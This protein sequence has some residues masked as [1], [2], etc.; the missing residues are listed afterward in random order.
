MAGSTATLAAIANDNYYFV[1]WGD[2]NTDNPR[3][4][5]VDQ[6]IT[7]AA[8]FNGTGVDENDGTAIH[9]Y[10]NPANDKIRLEG[11]EGDTEISIYNAFGICVKALTINGENEVSVN[12][13]AAGLYL[14]RID[15]HQTVKFV[16][17]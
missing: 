4:I 9:L 3:T 12:D 11:L 16:K 2:D 14:I 17:R 7:L 6:D 5:L 13:L 15:G 8:F 10:P 1:K